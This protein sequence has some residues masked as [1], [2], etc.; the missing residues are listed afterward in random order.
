MNAPDARNRALL[1]A[2]WI[3]TVAN[4]LLSAAKIAFGAMSGSLAVLS[5]GIDSATD[6]AISIAI[7]FTARIIRRPPSQKYV[8]GYEKAESIAVKI[9]SLIIFYAGARM[10]VSSAQRIFLEQGRDL[11][12]LSAVYVT[13]ASIVGKA[14]LA[15]YHFR[16][17]RRINSPLLLANAKNMRNDVLLSLSVLCGLFFTFRLR[18]PV[19]DA[20]TGLAVSLLIIRSSVSIFLDANV[21]LMDGV[22]DTSVYRKIFEAVDRVPG[23][24]NPHRVRSR[25]VGNGY[26]IDLDIEA[27]GNISLRQAH[28]LAEAVEQSIK[29]SVENVYDIVVHVEPA[30]ASHPSEKF[31]INKHI[32]Q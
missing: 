5:D 32:L 24:R 17:G 4:A 14:C 9:L 25:L 2:A 31:G 8:Y 1:A 28:A 10:L 20:I 7:I 23:A 18:M 13:L 11:P 29:R 27:D 16:Q 12:D 19:L 15:L 21:A 22:K 6:V 3:S 26:M 30:G